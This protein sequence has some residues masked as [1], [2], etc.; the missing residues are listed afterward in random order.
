MWRHPALTL[1][2]PLSGARRTA[3]SKRHRD[4]AGGERGGT[5][6][7]HPPPRSWARASAHRS[8]CVSSG[9]DITVD[10][11]EQHAYDYFLLNTCMAF[12]LEPA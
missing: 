11:V 12:I 7:C 8:E 4:P 2:T 3:G 9:R 6:G 10:T 5:A 1:L